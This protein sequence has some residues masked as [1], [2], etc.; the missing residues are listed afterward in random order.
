MSKSKFQTVDPS[1]HDD[2][3]SSRA[4]AAALGVRFK[5]VDGWVGSGHV[6][7][8]KVGRCRMVSLKSCLDHMASPT[9]RSRRFGSKAQPPR[10]QGSPPPP[11]APEPPICC[12]VVPI[13]VAGAELAGIRLNGQEVIAGQLLERIL[14]LQPKSLSARIG[15][16]AW[17]VEGED[18]VVL[19]GAEMGALREKVVDVLKTTPLRNAPNLTVL[20]EDGVA[21]VLT[22]IRSR[23]TNVLATTLLRSNFMRRAARAVIQG[24]QEGFARNAADDAT[25]D[26]LKGRLV[27]LEEITQQQAHH[28]AELKGDSEYHY[29]CTGELAERLEQAEQDMDGI[30][31]SAKDAS[32]EVVAQMLDQKLREFRAQRQQHQ[33]RSAASG[34]PARPRNGDISKWPHLPSWRVSRMVERAIP[35]QRPFKPHKVNAKAREA[36]HR[37]WQ[38]RGWKASCGQAVPGYTYHA[39]HPRYPD[40][41]K[42][43]Y[44]SP[45]FVD[46]LIRS[47]TDRQV[48]LWHDKEPAK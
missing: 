12:E 47:L 39:P 15:R 25:L 2:W 22:S 44:Y 26:D 45:A 9:Y 40:T 3:H 19:R 8:C 30:V 21:K 32:A 4:A 24:D 20:T 11:P 7:T 35:A 46:W 1:K 17:F 13:Q 38:S 23:K 16:D 31:E 27:Q 34:P 5:Q 6:D 43:Y 28:L 10:N 29:R 33:G 41:Q 14:G 37:Y 42:E 18:Y 48:Y 36:E